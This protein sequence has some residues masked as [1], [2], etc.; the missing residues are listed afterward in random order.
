[1]GSGK[2]T[3]DAGRSQSVELRE[4]DWLDRTARRW[5]QELSAAHTSSQELSVATSPL[6]RFSRGERSSRRGIASTD[7]HARVAQAYREL[8][9]A[10]LSY[11]RALHAPE[12]EDVLGELFVQV[13]RDIGRFRGNDTAL[14]RWIF[15]IAH[16]RVMD[17]HRMSRRTKATSPLLHSEPHLVPDPADPFDPELAAALATL[18]LEQREVVI[19]RFVADLSLESVAKITGRTTGAVKSLQHRALQNL[20]HTLSP[21]TSIGHGR[22]H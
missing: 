18:N 1:M 10:V 19:L 13:V 4:T 3:R 5:R 2:P 15:S 22:V 12:P 21:T 14:R 11:L 17:A 8:A 6:A 7:Q 9:P 16:N 20:Q